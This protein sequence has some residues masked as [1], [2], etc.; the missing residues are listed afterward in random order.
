MNQ[1]KNILQKFI[2]FFAAYSLISPLLIAGAGRCDEQVARHAC[3][4]CKHNDIFHGSQHNT[5]ASK[6]FVVL[7]AAISENRSSCSNINYNKAIL[8][9]SSYTLYNLHVIPYV[10]GDPNTISNADV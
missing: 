4:L 7:R 9:D 8:V 10:R 2:I 6:S 3:F 5:Q 1:S